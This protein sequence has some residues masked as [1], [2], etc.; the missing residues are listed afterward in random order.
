MFKHTQTIRGPLP[1]NYLSMSEHF[2]GLAFKELT[3]DIFHLLRCRFYILQNKFYKL[4]IFSVLEI[5][6]NNFKFNLTV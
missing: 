5:T 3:K 1:T 4:E 2:V 6:R